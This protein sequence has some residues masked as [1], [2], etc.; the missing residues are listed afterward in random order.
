M[1]QVAVGIY[2]VL[3]LSGIG[4]KLCQR[5]DDAVWR[6]GRKK[7][8]GGRIEQ[9]NRIVTCDPMGLRQYTVWLPCWHHR[10]RQAR[11]G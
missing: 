7:K 4:N 1:S 9:K 11:K 5:P 2:I 8:K 10:V 3:I 6:L